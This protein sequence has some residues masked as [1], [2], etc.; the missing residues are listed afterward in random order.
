MKE[1]AVESA[2]ASDQKYQSKKKVKETDL[3]KEGRTINVNLSQKEKRKAQ[4]ANHFR[5]QNEGKRSR[6]LRS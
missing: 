1:Q 4:G 2:T 6:K 5:T 3:A